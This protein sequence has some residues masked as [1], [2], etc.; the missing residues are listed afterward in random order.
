MKINTL[1]SDWSGTLSDDIL[2]VKDVYKKI[3]KTE[4]SLEEFR[5]TAKQSYDP[6]RRLEYIKTF[7]KSRYKPKLFSGVEEVLKKLYEKNIRI[8][9][10]TTHP[11][12]LFLKEARSILPY[13]YLFWTDFLDK[14]EKIPKILEIVGANPERTAVFDDTIYG[15]KGGKAAGA[16]TIAASYGYHTEEMLRKENPDFIIHSPLEILD[17]LD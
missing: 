13:L 7:S 8:I 12:V 14:I 1:I 3:Y 16:Y 9:I 17:I 10:C 15:I 5:K 4:I 11:S 2:V 6:K